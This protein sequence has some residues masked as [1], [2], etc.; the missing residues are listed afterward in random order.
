MLEVYF[1]WKSLHDAKEMGRLE[2]ERDDA[3]RNQEQ[4]DK[5]AAIRNR[6][7]NDPELYKLRDRF[8]KKH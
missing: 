1:R 8:T 5:A 3:I 7:R 4:R 2:A 6:L